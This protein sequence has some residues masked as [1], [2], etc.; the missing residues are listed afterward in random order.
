[1]I[2]MDKRIVLTK[3]QMKLIR[4]LRK[5]LHRL[6]EM[7]ADWFVNFDD[8]AEKLTIAFYNAE[9]VRSYENAC[10][11][12]KSVDDSSC[13]LDP[14][15]LSHLTLHA[16]YIGNDPM[17]LLENN[18]YVKDRIIDAYKVIEKKKLQEAFGSDGYRLQS[19]KKEIKE[20]AKADKELHEELDRW[21]STGNDKMIEI[22]LADIAANNCRRNEL[23]SEAIK[24]GRIVAQKKREF[25]KKKGW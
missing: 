23:K 11:C 19:I 13:V 25:L 17:L 18:Q 14:N 6:S 9:N 24:L 22:T 3:R 8:F 10:L 2:D 16:I 20:R 15:E 21:I 12:D 5:N 4:E 7:N 1:M